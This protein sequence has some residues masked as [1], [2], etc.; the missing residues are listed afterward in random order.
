MIK[1]N[2]LPLILPITCIGSRPIVDILDIG[3]P[4]LVKFERLLLN[5]SGTK[6]IRLKNNGKIPVNWKLDGIEGL[7]E[8]FNVDTTFGRLNP[9]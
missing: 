8:E 5:Q 3:E 7:P 4:P 9:T 1:N 6:E 2:P